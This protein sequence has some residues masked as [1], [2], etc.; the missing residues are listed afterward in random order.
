MIIVLDP[1]CAGFGSYLRPEQ[2]ERIIRTIPFLRAQHP[3]WTWET[4]VAAG[5][6]QLQRA[7]DHAFLK[8]LNQGEDFDSDTP[9]FEG[10]AD[11]AARASGAAITAMGHA[12]AGRRAFS[13]MRPPGHHATRSQI[14]GFCYAN[15]IA[16]AALEA[17]ERGVGRVAVWDFDGHHGNGTEDILM[18]REDFLYVSVH[19]F[20]GY[21]GTGTV[22]AGNCRNFPVQPRIPRQDLMD[23]L[24]RS[25]DAVVG[26]KPELVLISA[27]F[28]AYSGDPLLYLTLEAEDFAALGA[29]VRESGLPSAAILEGGYSRDLPALIDTF[30]GAWDV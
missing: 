3:D 13:L 16:V 30:L 25:W 7:H 9:W 23:V 28:D 24:R 6:A 15:H 8:R 20:P 18:G 22:S 5:V 12:L 19:Q 21:P 27:G 2:P 1:A 11:H 26:F 17:R 10:I 29:W 14:M 4:P